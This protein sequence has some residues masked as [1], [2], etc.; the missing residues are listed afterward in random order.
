MIK[1]TFHCPRL[2]IWQMRR[3]ASVITM[4]QREMKLKSGL[5]HLKFLWQLSTFIDRQEDRC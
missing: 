2:F 5:R 1:S 4:T 3:D